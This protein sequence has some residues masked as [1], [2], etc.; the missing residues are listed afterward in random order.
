MA[1]RQ[2]MHTRHRLQRRR[3]AIVDA[4]RRIIATDGLAGVT[5][6]SVADRA[7]AATG[8]VYRY[9]P[10]KVALL[11]DVVT[12]ICERELALVS[13]VSANLD[14]AAPDRLRAAVE[15]FSSR[16][17]ASGRTAYAVIAEPSVVEIE[18]VRTALRR[19]LA[20]RFTLIIRD[21]IEDG[22]L[23]EQ[24][25]DVAG[26]A[27]V[28]AMSEVLVGP[29]GSVPRPRADPAERAGDVLDFVMRSVGAPPV[30]QEGIRAR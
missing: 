29:V 25:A 15:V 8:T 26:V 19:D 4:T 9:F 27:I 1:Y 5:M 28:G 20:A 13:A 7:G 2:T 6:Q 18:V 14:L 16:A 17:I 21:G 24:S 30:R 11:A 22:S 12:V 3:E 10:S 23:P